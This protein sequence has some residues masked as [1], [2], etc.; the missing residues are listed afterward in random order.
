[1]PKYSDLKFFSQEAVKKLF[2]RALQYCDPKKLYLAL[3]GMYERT[4]QHKL[5]DDLL[6]KMIKKFKS[7]CK[8]LR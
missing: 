6:G 3:L 1:M 7:S 2:Y 4:E 8:V 5:A